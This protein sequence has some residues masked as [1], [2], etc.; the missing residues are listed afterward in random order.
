MDNLGFLN[1]FWSFRWKL[2]G[3]LYTLSYK[4]QLAA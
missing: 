1:L 4:Q 3:N 2:D